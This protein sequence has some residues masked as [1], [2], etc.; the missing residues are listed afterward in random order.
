MKKYI[1]CAIITLGII[2][3]MNLSV[4]AQK[5]RQL[6]F[7]A[8]KGRPTIGSTFTA[9]TIWLVNYKYRV[10]PHSNKLEFS[11]GLFF[12]PYESYFRKEGRSNEYLKKY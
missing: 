4:Q 8:F 1:T 10:V 6:T 7:S 11:V 2:I 12:D 3:V 9:S 5:Y